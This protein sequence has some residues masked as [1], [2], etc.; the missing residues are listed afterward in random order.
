MI[1]PAIAI[2]FCTTENLSINCNTTVMIISNIKENN[3]IKPK[4]LPNFILNI[5]NNKPIKNIKTNIPK[6][7]I[8]AVLI[9]VGE[10]RSLLDANN[11]PINDENSVNNINF[12]IGC[13][14]TNANK[15]RI[16]KVPIIN[17]IKLTGLLNNVV[18]TLKKIIN[19]FMKPIFLLLLD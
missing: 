18:F 2:P 19:V 9:I 11:K 17:N 4:V 8:K 12:K 15:P 1:N 3:N 6:T 16:I 7:P 5:I 14:G 10:K 13:I